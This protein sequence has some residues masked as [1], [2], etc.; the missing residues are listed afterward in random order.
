MVLYLEFIL[1]LFYKELNTQEIDL[2]ILISFIDYLWSNYKVAIFQS[3]NQLLQELEQLK[4]ANI[5]DIVDNDGKK[6]IKIK[7]PDLIGKMGSIAKSTYIYKMDALYRETIER[8][9]KAFKNFIYDSELC[10]SN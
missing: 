9:E 3:E 4:L 2:S 6:I 5:V 7:K 1:H 10:I 8:I